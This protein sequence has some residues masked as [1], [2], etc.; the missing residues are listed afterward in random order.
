MASVVA[1]SSVARTAISSVTQTTVAQTNS[2][3]KQTTGS[4]TSTDSSSSEIGKGLTKLLD[5]TDPKNPLAQAAKTGQQVASALGPY[6]SAAFAS[7]AAAML[8]PGAAQAAQAAAQGIGAIGGAFGGGGGGGSSGGAAPTK[9]TRRN[10]SEGSN[11]ESESGGGCGPGGC[12]P[13]RDSFNG[14]GSTPPINFGGRGDR[15]IPP[16]DSGN[17]VNSNGSKVY[18]TLTNI[19]FNTGLN[20]IQGNDGAAQV[21]ATAQAAREGVVIKNFTATWC[22]PCQQMASIV[23]N[24][25]KNTPIVKVDADLNQK[26]AIQHGVDSYPSF[27]AGYKDPNTNKF[28]ETGRVTGIVSEQTLKNLYLGATQARAAAIEDK[29]IADA[30]AK[31]TPKEVKETKPEEKTSKTQPFTPMKLSE[32]EPEGVSVGPKPK[33]NPQRPESSP[34]S[35][36]EV[37]EPS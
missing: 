19:D 7:P 33:E 3:N 34:K 22:G 10:N 21:G 29:K 32:K 18:G 11:S 9:N 13:P 16:T 17:G 35:K 27:V 24:L 5:F 15:Y 8:P 20:S 25:Q 36:N 26:L 28:V 4:E 30:K 23:S 14:G 37:D 1:T 12:R 31:E 6:A 2:S